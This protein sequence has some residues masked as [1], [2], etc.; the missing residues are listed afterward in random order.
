MRAKTMLLLA[1]VQAAFPALILPVAAQ[2]QAPAAPYPAMAPLA[3]YL[4]PE[5]DEIALARSGAPAEISK[6]ADV[7]VLRKDGYATAAKGTNGFLCIV[8]R[9]WANDTSQPDFWNPKLRAPNCFNHAAATTFEQI[10]LMKT[11]LVLEGKTKE[12][13]VRATAAA[14][15]SKKLPPLAPG[16]MCYM[17]SKQ[18]YLGDRDKAWHP[19]LMFFVA[20]DAAK[21]WGADAAGSP[22]IAANDPEE[23]VTIFMMVVGNWSD[24]SSGPPA[25]H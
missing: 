17:M 14:M 22:L 21:S 9:G 2:A 1:F 7:M 16:A 10:Y 6:N 24:G 5:S 12:E 4:M 15:D 19:H 3:Q 13:I 8:E 18:Q 25:S 23:R 11:R 20:G